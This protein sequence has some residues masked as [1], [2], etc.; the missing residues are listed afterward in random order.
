VADLHGRL[1]RTPNARVA[2]G[3]DVDRFFD[4]VVDAVGRLT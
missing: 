4:L 1:G 3:L 2:V